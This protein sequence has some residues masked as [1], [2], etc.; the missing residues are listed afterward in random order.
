MYFVA[1]LRRRYV[2]QLPRLAPRPPV[3]ISQE[4]TPELLSQPSLRPE[5]AA[6]LSRAEQRPDRKAQPLPIDLSQ[7]G[8]SVDPTVVPGSR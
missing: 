5:L 6:H 2:E 3:L 8:G 1:W 4:P 7:V